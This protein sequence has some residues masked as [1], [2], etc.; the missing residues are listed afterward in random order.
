MQEAEYEATDPFTDEVSSEQEIAE[1]E[2][3]LT[4]VD[5]EAATEDA[6]PAPSDTAGFERY[7]TV[8]L[9]DLDDF[10]R[11]IGKTGV[12]AEG[13]FCVRP[14]SECPT[15]AMGHLAHPIEGWI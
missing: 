5:E 9:D 13:Y 4:A 3:A 12:A 10:L 14:E 6:P 7:A 1:I 2:A 15:G 11:A 8:E